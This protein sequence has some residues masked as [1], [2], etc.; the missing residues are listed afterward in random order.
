MLAWEGEEFALQG[1]WGNLRITAREIR[2]AL[3]A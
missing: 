1:D 3:S 2:V